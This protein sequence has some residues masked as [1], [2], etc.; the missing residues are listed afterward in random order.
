MG[1]TPRALVEDMAD[2]SGQPA[3]TG[4]ATCHGVPGYEARGEKTVEATRYEQRACAFLTADRAV[5][6]LTIVPLDIA[7]AEGPV[8][9]EI[10]DA[11]EIGR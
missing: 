8:L 5:A 9:R 4:A 7:A 1:D 2:R 3:T 11:T 10:V 6:V